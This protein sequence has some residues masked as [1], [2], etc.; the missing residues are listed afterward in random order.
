MS[1][2]CGLKILKTIEESQEREPTD[3]KLHAVLLI[4]AEF[5]TLS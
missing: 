5:L 2:K 3:G 1:S 4:M